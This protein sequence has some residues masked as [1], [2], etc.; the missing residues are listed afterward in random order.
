MA[1]KHIM[2]P[3]YLT[4]AQKDR[5]SKKSKLSGFNVSEL[6]REAIDR[7]LND[8]TFTQ[9]E[10]AQFKLFS[11]EAS[12]SVKIMKK[13]LSDA[14]RKMDQILTMLSGENSGGRRD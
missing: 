5:L 1:T 7:F 12:K 8:D 14:H 3:I 11:A 9:E 10:K 6:I 2:T 4:P 13:E